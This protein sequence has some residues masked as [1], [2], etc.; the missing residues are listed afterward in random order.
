[1]AFNNRMNVSSLLTKKEKKYKIMEYIIT[2]ENK[3]YEELKL[4]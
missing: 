3:N 1:M 2:G 4:I